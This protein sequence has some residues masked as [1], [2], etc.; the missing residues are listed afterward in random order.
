LLC[1]KENKNSEDLGSPILK[2]VLNSVNTSR[3]MQ[4]KNI[5]LT[6]QKANFVSSL[7]GGLKKNEEKH[8]RHKVSNNKICC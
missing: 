3:T 4:D 8:T 2:N 5:L 6:P 7:Y 1:I